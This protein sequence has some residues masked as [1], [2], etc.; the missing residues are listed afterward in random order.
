MMSDVDQ[1]AHCDRHIADL[2]TCIENVEASVGSGLVLA[3][4]FVRLLEQT[5]ESWHE[6]KGKLLKGQSV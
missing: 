5:R 1:I 2:T 6:R 3:D 4:E